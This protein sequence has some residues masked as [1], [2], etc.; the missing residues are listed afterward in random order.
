MSDQKDGNEIPPCTF[1]VMLVGKE[2]GEMLVDEKEIE[3]L[4]V[5]QRDHDEP[6][7][8]DRKEQRDPR[9]EMQTPP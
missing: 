2:A 6:R 8:R 1:A 9:N 3:E 7:R 5:A 4:A